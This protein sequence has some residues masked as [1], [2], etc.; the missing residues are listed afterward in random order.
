MGYDSTGNRLQIYRIG[1]YWIYLYL[2]ASP[3]SFRTA[4][5]VSLL[6][7]LASCALFWYKHAHHYQTARS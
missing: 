4:P 3:S 2:S 6:L 1:R 5:A 7:P